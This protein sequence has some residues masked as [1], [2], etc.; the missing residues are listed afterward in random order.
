MLAPLRHRTFGS[1]E[2]ANRAIAAQLALV[3][4]EPLS[5]NRAVSRLSLFR[6]EEQAALRP[7]PPEPFVIGRWSRLKVPPDYHVGASTR[8][9]PWCARPER[10][11][12][13]RAGACTPLCGP[14]MAPTTAG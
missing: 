7:L 1:L 3:N 11:A 8:S 12:R 14:H 9:K 13:R 2:E 4:A 5:V 6:D 10:S